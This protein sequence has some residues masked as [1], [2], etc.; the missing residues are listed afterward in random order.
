[1]NIN[2]ELP[3]DSALNAYSAFGLHLV[4]DKPLPG[5]LIAQTGVPELQVFF[6]GKVPRHA[7]QKSIRRE[8]P[9]VPGLVYE[10]IPGKDS[11][12]IRIVHESGSIVLMIKDAT[13][14]FEWSHGI[15]ARTVEAVFCGIILKSIALWRQKFALHAGATENPEGKALVIAGKKGAGK[16]TL[17]AGFYAAGAR[18]VAEDMAAL[19]QRDGHWRVHSGARILKLLPQ[20]AAALVRGPR[21]TPD[22]GE[23]HSDHPSTADYLRS[24]KVLMD[25]TARDG[26]RG[27]DSLPLAAIY[28]LGSRLPAGAP[29]ALERLGKPQAVA[30][31]AQELS[32]V[33][34][35]LEPREDKQA[36]LQNVLALVQ[37]VPIYKLQLPNDLSRV[38]TIA[39]QLLQGAP[40][41]V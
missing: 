38:Q 21:Q 6:G 4:S 41:T 13:V 32:E 17:L 9:E 31:L 37:D 39:R 28:L 2:L 12:E 33:P 30:L 23:W 14:N 36:A 5:F 35:M 18:I 27:P 10:T 25:T 29:V 7:G 8:V 16:S 40:A 1:M 19:S 26:V 22:A 24:Q 3:A 34:E 11:L 20:A 15:D